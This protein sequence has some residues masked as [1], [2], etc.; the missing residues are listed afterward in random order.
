M[1]SFAAFLMVLVGL[2][3]LGV[4]LAAFIVHQNEQALVLQ[5]SKPTRFI[6]SPGLYWKIPFVET[7]TPF[8]KQILDLDTSS[9]EITASDQ[10]RLE[11]DAYT[12]YRIVD[13]LLFFQRVGTEQKV[14]VLVGLIIQSAIRR[15][16]GGSTLQDIVKDRREPLMAEIARIVGEESKAY[17]MEIVDVRIKRTD[18]PQAN[19]ESVFLRMRQDRKREATELRALG[20]AESNRIK[21]GADREVTV[22][23]ADAKNQADQ[24]MGAG[25]AERIRVLADAYNQDPEFFRFYRSMQ[26][27]ESSLKSSDTRVVVSP[28]SPFFRYFT[29]PTGA[30]TPPKPTGK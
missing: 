2:A 24:I 28:D 4:Y 7:V 20:E 8:S 21:A 19:L 15:V 14:N 23:T 1:K 22:I 18:L 9:Q 17:G 11:V 5:F 26:A 16:L 13:P 10:K 3:S 6:N 27:Y 12:R 29:D 25:D 30:G